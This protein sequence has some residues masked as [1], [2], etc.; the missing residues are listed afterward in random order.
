VYIP[1]WKVDIDTQC[2]IFDSL[3]SS[4]KYCVNLIKTGCLEEK[5][6]SVVTTPIEDKFNFNQVTD[7]SEHAIYY[8][9]ENKNEQEEYKKQKIEN[10][11]NLNNF[12]INHSKQLN[13]ILNIYRKSISLSNL[14]YSHQ[15]SRS[16]SKFESYIS[17]STM[18]SLFIDVYSDI[19]EK[20]EIIK[21]A[22]LRATSLNNILSLL[23]YLL[24]GQQAPSPTPFDMELTTRTPEVAILV[25]LFLKIYGKGY[26]MNNEN[27]RLKNQTFLNNMN[28]NKL[29]EDDF[30]NNNNVYFTNPAFSKILKL[31][32]FYNK[33]VLENTTPEIRLKI[34]RIL[35]NL[36]CQ[37]EIWKGNYTNKKGENINEIMNKYINNKDEE[38]SND[39]Y[40]WMDFEK[41]NYV[42]LP[43]IIEQNQ[44]IF[45]E[46][47]ERSTTLFKNLLKDKAIRKEII[48]SG[49]L[50]EFFSINQLYRIINYDISYLTYSHYFA[51]LKTL[52]SDSRIRQHSDYEIP[53]FLLYF[54]SGSIKKYNEILN[55]Q[56]YKNDTS[57]ENLNKNLISGYKR[58]YD[59]IILPK[60]SSEESI[61]LK[62]KILKEIS[63]KCLKLLNE[64][65]RYDKVTLELLT[66]IVIEDFDLVQFIHPAIY[67]IKYKFDGY[68]SISIVPLIL[69]IISDENSDCSLK[70]ESLALLEYLA[71]IPNTFFQ[72][73]SYPKGIE[74][75]TLWTFITNPNEN[76]I[77]ELYEKKSTEIYIPTAED[78][79][80]NITCFI[81]GKLVCS[82]PH[83]KVFVI[84][85]GY[86]RIVYTLLYS[87]NSDAFKDRFKHRMEYISNDSNLIDATKNKQNSL[88][89][90]EMDL[91][92]YD[93]KRKTN[94]FKIMKIIH[95]KCSEKTLPLLR[96]FYYYN[97][98]NKNTQS[99]HH[100]K[101]TNAIVYTC[102]PEK[103]YPI[104]IDKIDLEY[105][106]K[107]IDEFL[108]HSDCVM[109]MLMKMLFDENI[110]SI[111]MTKNDINRIN[112]I[113]NLLPEDEHFE[114]FNI[115][116]SNND[117]N[118]I[119]ND[120]N[121][122]KDD[123]DFI[124]YNDSSYYFNY[125][126][127][128]DFGI[129]N[130]PN[131]KHFNHFTCIW[132]EAA[133]AIQYLGL[134]KRKEWQKKREIDKKAIYYLVNGINYTSNNKKSNNDDNE[135]VTFVLENFKKST[136]SSSEVNEKIIA[137]KESLLYY[138][139][140]FSVMLTGNFS[141]KDEDEINIQDI[142]SKDFQNLINFIEY[143]YEVKGK[144]IKKT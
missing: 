111:E 83:Q 19:D 58:T 22:L 10:Q 63:N 91:S 60:I 61:S 13:F 4:I 127:N 115:N 75:I 79:A 2:L 86:F 80:N 55:K 1:L 104:L 48:E 121:N 16:S 64:Y 56:I 6:K 34:Y 95:D 117:N 62:K 94:F 7:I 93:S 78:N 12:I 97:I 49:I 106:I 96:R 98:R 141:E 119:K 20:N 133:Y 132:M 72:L 110:Y 24:V 30:I 51:L 43:D 112:L 142:D 70:A 67:R 33:T 88:L 37:Y 113:S 71:V 25:N 103:H 73:L 53:Q 136:N 28:N 123:S 131:E 122:I 89:S 85:D 5:E 87:S 81:I 140:I 108:N 50:K 99:A 74:I 125:D 18:K 26:V 31:L 118:V 144:K 92:S 11:E 137:K 9:D 76:K 3:I 15:N 116:H 128:F 134:L 66:K 36:S 38:I 120:N 77:K 39:D 21:K 129:D 32:S 59:G 139:P 42:I 84:V 114:S 41:E 124:N 130:N 44:N 105:L 126:F 14:L 47:S 17:S 35:M 143:Y 8:T 69:F 46:I 57:L 52:A 40:D 135:Y 29:E 82:L 90:C 101:I 109:C 68:Y 102:S 54:F 100:I 107:G 45:S 138:S 23:I 65:F 27:D